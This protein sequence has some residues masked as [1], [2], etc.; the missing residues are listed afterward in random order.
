[1]LA[2]VQSAVNPEKMERTFTGKVEALSTET[3]SQLVRIGLILR[4][5]RFS[6]FLGQ[7]PHYL[8]GIG[9]EDFEELEDGG[10]A[11]DVAA[12]FD[13]SDVL[14]RQAGALCELLLRPA[15]TFA[16]FANHLAESFGVRIESER[17]RHPWMILS[18]KP[19]RFQRPWID[20]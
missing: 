9:A 8:T 18:V 10:E 12:V 1:M 19:W 13:D 20:Q 16:M 5:R 4:S 2:V 11:W 17:A 14:R 15:E 6:S 7:I 3:D